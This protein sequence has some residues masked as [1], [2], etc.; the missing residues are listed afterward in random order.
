MREVLR[1]DPSLG[2]L[3]DPVVADRAGRG[4]GVLDLRLG[5][6]LEQCRAVGVLGGGGVLDPHAGQA[7]GHQLDPDPAAGRALRVLLGGIQDTE[8]VLHRVTVFVRHDVHLRERA[9]AGAEPLLQDLEERRVDVDRLVQGAIERADLVGR[10]AAGGLGLA[11]VDDGLRRLPRGVPLHRGRIDLGPVVEQA[12]LGG[13]DPA[14]VVAVG[15]G[16]GLALGG[17]RTRIDLTGAADAGGVQRVAAA[18]EVPAALGLLGLR[19]RLGLAGGI[20]VAAHQQV[21]NQ[22]DHAEDAA[23][24]ADDHA[25][26]APAAA[27]GADPRGVQ[28][29]VVVEGHARGPPD[30]RPMRSAGA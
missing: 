18:A 25:P 19:R 6:R 30:R 8:S 27:P 3:L 13:D 2:L 1:G 16:A 7:V 21:Q 22:G 14:L 12:V 10:R 4:Q 24:P 9:A 17:Q 29:G 26:A 28:L 23:T 5:D 15:V 11:A 20:G